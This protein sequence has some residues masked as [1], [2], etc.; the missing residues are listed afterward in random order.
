LVDLCLSR[1]LLN[2]EACEPVT[3]V[4]AVVF[5]DSLT[6]F[7]GASGSLAVPDHSLSNLWETTREIWNVSNIDHKR[8]QQK[9]MLLHDDHGLPTPC[10]A[11]SERCS[12]LCDV[13][14]KIE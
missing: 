3:S 7:E 1:T 6:S 11:F 10:R 12:V 8:G 5:P 2:L 9:R 4:I 14:N 13:R